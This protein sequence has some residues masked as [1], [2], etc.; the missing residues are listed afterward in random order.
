MAK[1]IATS[2]ALRD[3]SYMKNN[4]ERDQF[5]FNLDG[6]IKGQFFKIETDSKEV[7]KEI[8]KLMDSASD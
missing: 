6:L 3:K 7:I 2:Q 1:R 4:S 8:I 5:L